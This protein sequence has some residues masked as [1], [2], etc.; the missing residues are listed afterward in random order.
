[1]RKTQTLHKSNLVRGLVC[2][3]VL[4]V[5]FTLFN[6]RTATRTKDIRRETQRAESV[7]QRQ[8]I[9]HPLY[10]EFVSSLKTRASSLPLPES[11][12]L[13][14]G[15]IEGV[16]PDITALARSCNLL[17][18]CVN[19]DPLSL[20]L[21]EG[22]MAVDI[23]VTGGLG[24]FRDFYVELGALPYLRDIER[25]R[26]TEGPGVTSFQLKAWVAVDNG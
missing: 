11:T 5:F 7:R 1:M 9:L 25:M 16:K 4:A 8:Q 10:A 23:T 13:A 3:A 20:A 26:V 2:L 22:R 24:D 19:C 17:P 14:T 12:T 21:E 18:Q 15:D 6:L